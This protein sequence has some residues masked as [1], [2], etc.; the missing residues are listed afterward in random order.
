MK[1]SLFLIVF[2]LSGLVY[3]QKL[4]IKGTVNSYIDS[5]N[6]N[7][8]YG[9]EVFLKNAKAGDITDDKGTFSIKSEV[10]L[11]DTLII[12]ASGYY[13]DTA[14]IKNNESVN[15]EITL[16]PEFVTE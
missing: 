8:L 7:P 3:G 12:R 13:S 4:S 16:Y 5:K 11:P 9:A 15:Y 6:T 1:N 2:L 10:T 14:I